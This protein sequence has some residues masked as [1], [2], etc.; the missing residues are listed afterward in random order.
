MISNIFYDIIKILLYAFY[1]CTLHKVDK[2]DI[3]SKLKLQIYMT[4]PQ[5]KTGIVHSNSTGS[6]DHDDKLRIEEIDQFHPV[7][8]QEL[9]LSLSLF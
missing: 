3:C 5:D 9:S 1:V 6:C 8:S 2:I 7:A 4:F